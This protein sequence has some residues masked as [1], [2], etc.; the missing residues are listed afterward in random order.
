MAPKDPK[1]VHILAIAQDK[2]SGVLS[3]PKVTPTDVMGVWY[4]AR[5]DATKDIAS[6]T[7]VILFMF[8]G[9]YVMGDP[10]PGEYIECASRT[11]FANEHSSKLYQAI[12]RSMPRTQR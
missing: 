4:P 11:M 5:Y 6:K 3:D 7:K 1:Q 10:N 8:G 9:A 2:L 12:E